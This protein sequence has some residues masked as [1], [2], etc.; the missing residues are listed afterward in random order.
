MNVNTFAAD[1]AGVESSCELTP[2]AALL[3][4]SSTATDLPGQSDVAS[5]ISHMRSGNDAFP[6]TYTYYGFDDSEQPHSGK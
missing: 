1:R 3:N 2:S 6:F 4:P 5:A